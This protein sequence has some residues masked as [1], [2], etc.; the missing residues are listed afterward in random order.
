MSEESVVNFFYR[1][2]HSVVQSA[3]IGNWNALILTLTLIPEK[4]YIYIFNQF[5][6]I[7]RNA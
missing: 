5:A 3:H 7:R 4:N 2:D 1:S 6:F